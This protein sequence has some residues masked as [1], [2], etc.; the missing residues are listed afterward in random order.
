LQGF[1]GWVRLQESARGERFGC[2]RVVKSEFDHV[3]AKRDVRCGVCGNMLVVAN[4]KGAGDAACNGSS[5]IASHAD[6][7]KVFLQ[8]R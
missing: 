3:D 1:L 4:D 2:R 8:L 7:E 6:D 5:K